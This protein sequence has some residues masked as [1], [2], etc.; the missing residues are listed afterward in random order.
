VS[1][2]PSDRPVHDC[3]GRADVH[4]A[5]M[6]NGHQP[7]RKKLRTKG[8]LRRSCSEEWRRPSASGRRQSGAVSPTFNTC[9]T[10]SVSRSPPIRW[11][12]STQ[13]TALYVV[14][15]SANLGECL[16]SGLA[17]VRRQAADRLAGR[18]GHRRARRGHAGA[19]ATSGSVACGMPRWG[20][21]TDQ[22]RSRAT[23]TK[24]SSA[25]E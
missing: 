8:P 12:H 13:S 11:L 4:S 18:V 23:L 9:D 24:A 3:E 19:L 21:S 16:R 6:Q 2:P 20:T 1:A 17:S 25:G 14:N 10:T 22:S 15:S 7:P 5:A